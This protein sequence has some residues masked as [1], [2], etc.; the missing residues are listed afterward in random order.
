MTIKTYGRMFTDN[1][2]GI[3]QLAITDGTDG[4]AIVTGR[5]KVDIILQEFA[6]KVVSTRPPETT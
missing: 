6:K 5:N 4:Q 2:V 3:T 1:T